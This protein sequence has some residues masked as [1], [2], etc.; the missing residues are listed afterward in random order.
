MGGRG[1][2]SWSWRSST[3]LAGTVEAVQALALASR[4]R[5]TVKRYMGV[6]DR[7]AK[8]CER[9]RLRP[10][11]VPATPADV[12]AYLKRLVEASHPAPATI[13]VVLAAFKWAHET[14]G[15]TNPCED[16]VLR[17][18]AA[19]ARRAA[20]HA[21]VR[22]RPLMP[23]Q[24]QAVVAVLVAVRHPVNY[25]VAAML[26]LSYPAFL[27]FS[28]IQVLR[29]SDL[30]AAE[31]CI[32][33][34]V[35]KSK[36]N[37]L[38]LQ[39]DVRPV[40]WRY[41]RVDVRQLLQDY[42]SVARYTAASDPETPMWLRLAD[43]VPVAGELIPGPAAY[44]VFRAALGAVGADARRFTWHSCRAGAA[45]GALL[46]RIPREMVMK[47]GNWRS[48]AVNVYLR[49]DEP[50]RL[51]A[52]RSML[53]HTPLL[54]VPVEQLDDLAEDWCD[55]PLLAV[56]DHEMAEFGPTDTVEQALRDGTVVWQSLID[57]SHGGKQSKTGDKGATFRVG[58]KR[59]RAKFPKPKAAK[60][61]KGRKASSDW[62]ESDD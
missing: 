25:Q 51:D 50:A 16:K 21:V 34:R 56:L 38:G 31:S 28:E 26:A 20:G 19:G 57:F 43:G 54:H 47:L 58:G 3:S 13:S 52:V 60:K 10:P 4:A 61:R 27:R 8:D 40:P 5:S 33:L 49:P 24:L 48:D 11:F 29:W 9:F 59:G 36:T 35:R 23:T 41:G 44:Q 46:Q 53:A 62:D 12:V 6:I 22:V 30:Q 1:L 18:V 37:Q 15:W 2:T 42:A 7:Y 39:E 14:M 17:N 55:D 45:T 32:L